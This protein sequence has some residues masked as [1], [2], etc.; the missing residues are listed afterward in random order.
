MYKVLNLILDETKGI[1]YWK[2]N[3]GIF[4]FET[5]VFAALFLM[6]WFG[7]KP[8]VS[9]NMAHVVTVFWAMCTMYIAWCSK[10]SNA[11]Q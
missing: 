5:I 11:K 2:E 7:H 1:V 6:V 9:R 8:E 10:W 3:I 4:V